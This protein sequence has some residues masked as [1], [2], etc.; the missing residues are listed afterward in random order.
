VRFGSEVLP[1]LR[2][3]SFSNGLRLRI[4]HT[5]S[6]TPDRLA[7]LDSL[8]RNKR[9]VHVGCCDHVPL[10]KHKLAADTWL[11]SRICRVATS[12]YGVD[13]SAEGIELMRGELGYVEVANA[14]IVRDEVPAIKNQDWDYMVLGEILEHLDDPVGFLTS[15]RQRYRAN[16]SR[17]L[18]TVPN[19]LSLLNLR[20]AFHHQ[21]C[22]NTDHRHWLSPYTLGR[23]LISSGMQPE[24]FF[25]CEPFPA[26]DSWRR[27]LQPR[28]A[29]V[30]FL[31]RRY[32]ALREGLIMIARI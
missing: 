11:H 18:I 32:P 25:F 31:L 10:I 16:I 14:D 12:C 13:T 8:L 2:G 17:V 30:S 4:A 5:E 9:V 27:R 7:M 3:E 22:I 6:T 26:H 20:F 21:E 29:V 24:E 15:I 1:Y 19:A 28:V 23:M